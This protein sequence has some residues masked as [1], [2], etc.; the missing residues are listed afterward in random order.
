MHRSLLLAV[1]FATG[2][3]HAETAPPLLAAAEELLKQVTPDQ[4]SYKHEEPQVRWSTDPAKP[5]YCHT[6]CSGLLMALYEH[7]DP[8][9]YGPGAWHRWLNSRRPTARRFHEAIIGEKG[10]KLI[11]KISEAKPGD[12]LA[13][14]Y[15]SGEENTGHTMLVAEAPKKMTAKEPLV[16]NTE[17]WEVTVLDQTKSGH[18]P[19]D[20]RR[21]ADG[22]FTGGLG[23][24]VFRVYV[25]PDGTTAG[26]TWSTFKNSK[27]YGGEDRVLVIGRPDP[28]FK[29]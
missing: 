19:T 17:Q 8:K 4:M 25:K 13:A 18:G 7:L 15:Q 29:P 10:F 14:R 24:G 5:A 2:L 11:E 28:N 16:D 6:D 21:T 23:K 22:K 27:F 3:A 20:T 9:T 26:Y 12:I 1:F